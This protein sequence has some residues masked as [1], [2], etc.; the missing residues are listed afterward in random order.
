M[1][2]DLAQQGLWHGPVSALSWRPKSSFFQPHPLREQGSW[3]W[4][5][6]LPGAAWPLPPS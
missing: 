4:C 6:V 5:P 3:G 1:F 2:H